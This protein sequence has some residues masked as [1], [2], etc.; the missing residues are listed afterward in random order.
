MGVIL[1]QGKRDRE[2]EREREREG[3]D[4]IRE[5]RY[6]SKEGESVREKS[7]NNHDQH[8]LA[9]VSSRCR[10]TACVYYSSVCFSTRCATEDPPLSGHVHLN[11]R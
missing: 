4:K 6:D 7:R 2:R 1:C 11:A 9:V 3:R 8:N 10:T 5:K